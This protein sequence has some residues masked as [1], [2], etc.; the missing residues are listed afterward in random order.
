MG[1]SKGTDLLMEQN[2]SLKFLQNQI[3]TV[4]VTQPLSQPGALIKTQGVGLKSYAQSPYPC[5]AVCVSE[6]ESGP[7]VPQYFILYYIKVLH[8]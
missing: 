7:D 1:H 3:K 8:H 5:T 6:L 2:F 4:S